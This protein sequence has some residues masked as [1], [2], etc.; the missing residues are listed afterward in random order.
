MFIVVLKNCQWFPKIDNSVARK[1]YQ[2][3]DDKSECSVCS[4]RVK[5]N[6]YLSFSEMG[7]FYSTKFKKHMHIDSERIKKSW[8]EFMKGTLKM[9][10]TFQGTLVL[11]TFFSNFFWYGNDAIWV[12]KLYMSSV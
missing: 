11:A 9:P 4:I 1:W 6:V 5:F 12:C 7:R 8:K 3:L 2:S 10:G